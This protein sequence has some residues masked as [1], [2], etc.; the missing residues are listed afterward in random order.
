MEMRPIVVGVDGSEPGR[1]AVALAVRQARLHGRPLRLVHAFIWPT[2]GVHV[3]PS[4]EGP[5]EGGL[6]AEA[7]RLLAE[8]LAHARTADPDLDITGEVVAG[9][10]VPV[11]LAEARHASLVVLGSRGLGGFT[12]L[13]VGSV[14]VQLAAHSPGPVLVAR[15]EQRE[16]GPVVVGVDGSP[17][18]REAL[19][20]ALGEA[21]VRGTELIALNTWW[22][23]LP[24]RTEDELPLVY[25][26]SDV[27][28][29]QA[30]ML[31]AAVAGQRA[32]F[33]GVNVRERV[34]H[35]RAAHALVT[36]SE[37]AQLV[38]VGARGRGGFS[39]LLLGSVSQALLHHARC[40][41]A[42]VRWPAHAER[43][44]AVGGQRDTI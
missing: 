5:P 6:A 23:R 33:P 16:R 27:E 41:V 13:L 37:T 21:A 29:T 39:G 24:E 19:G 18:S 14:A 44:A 3:G 40:P 7:D 12:G 4:P 20:F 11:L 35:A 22:G 15:G 25:D 38:V 30:S 31:S 9:A 2:L 8:A 32:R 1:V 36:A 34:R 42:I 26:A 28:A 10:P 43:D 17:T